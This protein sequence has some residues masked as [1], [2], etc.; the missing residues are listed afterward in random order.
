MILFALWRLFSPACQKLP[1]K[2]TYG[3]GRWLGWTVFWCWPR[4]RANARLNA[5]YLLG[6][7]QDARRV[8]GLAMRMVQNY[9]Y[10]IVDFLRL[11]TLGRNGWEQQVEFYGW[12]ELDAVLK[13]GKGA[14]LVGLHLGSWDLGAAALAWKKYPVHVVVE[15]QP[16]PF[17]DRLVKD[18]R[19]HTGVNVISS[20]S[21]RA[22]VRALKEGGVLCLLID[23][24]CLK[25]GQEVDF[26]GYPAVVPAGA[27]T[28]SL[29]TGAK[30][31]PGAVIRQSEGRFTVH[32][33]P[34]IPYHV[35]G[36]TPEQAKQLTQSIMTCLEWIVRRH[37]EQ[38]CIYHPFWRDDR[39]PVGGVR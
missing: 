21:V 1:L 28:L 19:R 8:E 20:K 2:V 30:V 14:I 35:N 6:F 16:S 34:S 17:L 36:R 15:D 39:Q 37:A 11:P 13:E 24:P 5:R 4:L 38:W 32:L 22:M 12:S 25:G 23:R 31:L 10:Y 29:L 3:V 18:S 9:A 27:A 33:G 7:P 26:L